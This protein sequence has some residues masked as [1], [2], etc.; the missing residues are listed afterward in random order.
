MNY[1]KCSSF[2]LNKNVILK[3]IHFL[4]CGNVKNEQK[5]YYGQTSGQMERNEQSQL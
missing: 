2:S 4:N 1:K 3:P 5:N